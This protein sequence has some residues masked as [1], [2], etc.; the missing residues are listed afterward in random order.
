MIEAPET[1][2]PS[3]VITEI[4]GNMSLKTRAELA[5]NAAYFWAEK[6]DISRSVYAG[7]I[8]E[9]FPELR[10][11]VKKAQKAERKVTRLVEKLIG[12]NPC[13]FT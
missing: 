4:R 13:D 2:G 8:F 9:E 10:K 12:E 7:E 1:I 6:R 11:A 5:R 3:K